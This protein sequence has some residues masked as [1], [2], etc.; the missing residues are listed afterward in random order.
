MRIYMVHELCFFTAERVCV[1]EFSKYRSIFTGDES[2]SLCECCRLQS[3][4]I[5]F[6]KVNVTDQDPVKVIK[7]F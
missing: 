7:K 2:L 1:F 3:V 4:V 5:D 6:F